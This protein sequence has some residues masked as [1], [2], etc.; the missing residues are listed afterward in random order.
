MR[1]IF[2]AASSKLRVLHM[3]A[4]LYIISDKSSSENASFRELVNFGSF[5]PEEG[6]P[7]ALLSIVLDHLQQ[8]LPQVEDGVADRATRH[9]HCAIE[10]L[11]G[12][13]SF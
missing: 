3:K 12:Q 1:T 8:T 5:W 2:Q 7:A 13:G 6:Y 9:I 11:N 4:Q 10:I